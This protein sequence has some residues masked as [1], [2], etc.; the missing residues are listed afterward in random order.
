MSEQTFHPTAA[1]IGLIFIVLGVVFLLDQLDVIALQARYIVP[2]MVI[3]LGLAIMAG[4]LT[5]RDRL[6]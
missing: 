2:A 4:S 1:F 5:R 3:G 6:S